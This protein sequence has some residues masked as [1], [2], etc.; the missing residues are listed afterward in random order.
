MLLFSLSVNAQM[1][2]DR[3]VNWQQQVNYEIQVKLDDQNH[4]L[5][6]YEK[7]EY[8]NNSP[9]ALTEIWIHLWPNAYANTETPFAKQQVE[10]GKLDHYYAKDDELGWIDS[11]SFTVNGD[12]VEM[13]PGPSI[14]MVYLKLLKPLSSGEYCIIRSPFRVKVPKNF[15]RLGRGD[16]SYQITQWYPKPAVYDANGW[17]PMPYLDQGEFYSEFG[18]F[19]V[20]IDLPETYVLAATGNLVAESKS[21][22][23]GNKIY[24]Y[25]QL[26]VHDFAWFAD[27]KFKVDSAFCKLPSGRTVVCL[28]Y[29]IKEKDN[30]KFTLVESIEYLSKMVGE[31]PYETAKV[32]IGPLF[33]GGGMEY[34]TIAVCTN[35]DATVVEH[36]VGHNWFYGILGSNE[37][38][39]AWMDEG[40][41][42]F[43]ESRF[44]DRSKEE[45]IQDNGFVIKSN[46]VPGMFSPEKMMGFNYNT[47]NFQHTMLFQYQ[48]R[49]NDDQA[50]GVHSTE[51]SSL[52]YGAIVYGK[53]G[54]IFNYL[55]AY[56]GNQVFDSCMH[57]YFQQWKFRHPLPGDLRD[58]FEKITDKNLSWFFD[59]L[60]NSN[61][62]LDYQIMGKFRNKI[63]GLD[64]I[65]I[66]N[67]GEVA[68]PLFLGGYINGKWEILQVEGFTGLKSIAVTKFYEKYMIDPQGNMPE[69]QRKNNSIKCKG[70]FNKTEKLRLK[71][72][73]NLE[74][75][76]YTDLYWSPML[77]L[78]RY[79]G[80]MFGLAFYNEAIPEK[81]FSWLAAP[82]FGLASQRL[83]GFAQLGYKINFRNEQTKQ[84]E[85]RLNGRKFAYANEEVIIK[86]ERDTS[87]KLTNISYGKRIEGYNRLQPEIIVHIRKDPRSSMERTFRL[88]SVIVWEET[89][90]I[91]YPDGVNLL[92][93]VYS[94]R[95][96]FFEAVLGNN[97]SRSINPY[98]VDLG[99]RLHQKFQYL[100]ATFVGGIN[101]FNKN[102]KLEYRFFAGGLMKNDRFQTPDEIERYWMYASGNS[103]QQDYTYDFMIP[104]RNESANLKSGLWAQQILPIFG[105]MKLPAN[106][107]YTSDT[108]LSSL[109]IALP[110]P[111]KV[112]VKA[113]LDMCFFNS[114][115]YDNTSTSH[116]RSPKFIYNAGF[117]LVVIP[118]V[119]EIYFPLLMSPEM[120]NYF[121]LNNLS[122][123]QKISFLL[124]LENLNPLALKKIL[125]K[126]NF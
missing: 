121:T 6:G 35:G 49:G 57:S 118:K 78:N 120:K 4:I 81:K 29:Y 15:S 36:E 1:H 93:Q 25:K 109:G 72:G 34:P 32:V 70:L 38:E 112:P 37:R 13:R 47:S 23:A 67:N 114:L 30:S 8:I 91:S 104:G 75:P 111:G 103:G 105:G 43:Y 76:H 11:L 41:N 53:A 92:R 110:A 54:L 119:L 83:A 52:N 96:N 113:Y 5:N 12:K 101:L 42:S 10:N 71:F 60:I 55:K 68:G 9:D 14:D 80:F 98:K 124:N 82:M 24:N 84:I 125:S 63:A 18:N 88:R 116:Q 89:P 28:M 99:I 31:Y 46:E 97:N 69:L 123:R 33:A 90:H 77:G 20:S 73:G 59:D 27:T 19:N 100:H 86:G 65:D 44:K 3:Q 48:Q 40:I 61:K 39:H 74:D 106:F 17:N 95:S 108:W 45:Y 79:N 64:S 126:I 22:T 115:S 7:I 26:K 94:P 62:V 56:L 102:K 117:A 87:G 122:Y 85:L 58:V 16:S 21:K 51:F 107:G 50:I 66:L 2:K